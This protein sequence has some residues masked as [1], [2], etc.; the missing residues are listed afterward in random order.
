M[1]LQ[2]RI[3]TRIRKFDFRLIIN[4]A[5]KLFAIYLFTIIRQFVKQHLFLTVCVF[6]CCTAIYPVKIY[7]IDKIRTGAMTAREN[8]FRTMH[9]MRNVRGRRDRRWI[10]HRERR[11]EEPEKRKDAAACRHVYLCCTIHDARTGRDR[12]DRERMQTCPGTM[13]QGAY[14]VEGG[15][16]K[17]GGLFVRRRLRVYPGTLLK[18]R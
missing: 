10:P 8:A 7:D 13:S 1:K 2:R 11:T 5:T 3:N 14:N 17:V 9:T 15:V 4:N 16:V 18:G 6:Y 12:V